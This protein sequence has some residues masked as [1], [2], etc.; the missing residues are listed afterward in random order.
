MDPL[1]IAD[2]D[3]VLLNVIG[4][5]LRSAGF[6]GVAAY[7]GTE[8]IARL[9][10]DSFSLVVL[11]VEMRGPDGFD[12][13]TRLQERSRVPV[14]LLSEPSAE[15]DALRGLEMGADDYLIKPFDTR[16]L[17]ARVHALLRRSGLS[18]TAL[19]GN[20]VLDREGLRLDVAGAQ[21]QLS[22]LEAAVL[23]VLMTSAGR[24]VDTRTLMSEIWGQSGTQER[25]AL[26]QVI[27]RLRRKLNRNATASVLLETS[28]GMG[29]CWQIVGGEPAIETPLARG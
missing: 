27:H 21:F 1:L 12:V 2:S 17:V 20:A 4:F 7:D 26:K 11:D 18:P 8:A 25:K 29:Y 19:A 5:A 28:R 16:A 15:S 9:E 3:D 10:R 24:Y 13:W 6:E 14:I 22:P 23:G